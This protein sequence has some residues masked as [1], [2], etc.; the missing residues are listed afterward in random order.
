[1]DKRTRAWTSLPLSD[2][3]EKLISHRAIKKSSLGDREWVKVFKEPINS[4]NFKDVDA[5]AYEHI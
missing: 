4:E 3:V 1:M 2:Y 5:L